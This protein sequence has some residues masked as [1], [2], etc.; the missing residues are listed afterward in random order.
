MARSCGISGIFTGKKGDGVFFYNAQGKASEKQGW[1]QYQPKVANP[2]SYEQAL[3]RMKL[4]PLTSFY[5][6]L[7]NVIRRGFEGV[8]YGSPSYHEFM[9][10]NLGRSTGYPYVQ[11]GAVDVPPGMYQISKGSL[12][13]ISIVFMYESTTIM[14]AYT[15]I[16]MGTDNAPTTKGEAAQLIINNNTDI[17]DGDQLTFIFVIAAEGAYYYRVA[18]WVLDTNDE[19]ALNAA[20]SNG[21]TLDTGMYSG[22]RRLC[23]AI[24]RA[25][26]EVAY[27]AACIQSRDGLTEHLRSN[28][29]MFVDV[30]VGES[31]YW[32]AESFKSA[33]LSYMGGDGSGIDWPTQYI[34]ADNGALVVLPVPAAANS[35]SAPVQALG[36]ETQDG[37]AL[38]VQHIGE[39]LADM[40]LINTDGTPMT[41]GS[42]P[43]TYT[44][45]AQTIEYD[46][47]RYGHL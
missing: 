28:S 1:R 18:S 22:T 32:D 47:N 20:L 3:Q 8:R 41:S 29:E 44:G 17:K 24:S 5:N 39:N 34:A 35:T 7:K 6:N 9:R 11:K 43:V 25:E 12:P 31:H 10:L 21:L 38:F 19:S 30:R 16:L 42:N 14:Q 40:Q 36:F 26:D 4:Y 46:I 33:V 27:A 23:F 45:T 37:G 15:N 2:R 13:Q